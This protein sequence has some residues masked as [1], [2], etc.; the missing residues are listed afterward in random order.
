MY[1]FTGSIARKICSVENHAGD[2]HVIQKFK[3]PAWYDLSRITGGVLHISLTSSVRTQDELKT[4]LD[5]IIFHFEMKTMDDKEERKELFVALISTGLS[6]GSS[7]L[8]AARL[9]QPI[10]LRSTSRVG[11][12]CIHTNGFRNI[13]GKN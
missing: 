11:I 1:N 13:F 6:P 3:S 5:E 10:V 8:F 9:T 12:Q 4:Q 7:H 2:H